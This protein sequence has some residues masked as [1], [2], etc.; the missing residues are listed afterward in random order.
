MP[1]VLLHANAR[2]IMGLVFY[3]DTINSEGY[4]SGNA[5]CPVASLI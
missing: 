1:E 2:S 4:T 3:A 5:S